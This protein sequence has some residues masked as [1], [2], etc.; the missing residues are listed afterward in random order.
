MVRN[1]HGY[2]LPS[3][4]GGGRYNTLEQAARAVWCQR[5]VVRGHEEIPGKPGVFRDVVDRVHD[6]RPGVYDARECARVKCPNRA[7]CAYQKA[8]SAAVAARTEVASGVA[9]S[10]EATT[11]A[12]E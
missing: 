4:G 9:S 6:P 11:V 8:H 5:T 7:E 1:I 10:E 3:L 12:A 2:L